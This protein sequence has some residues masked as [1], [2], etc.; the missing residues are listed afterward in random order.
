MKYEVRVLYEGVATYVVEASDVDSA[1]EAGRARYVNG[2][3]EDSTGNEW[4][5][6]ESVVSVWGTANWL[7]REVYDMFGVRFAG[8]P[9]LR[10]ILL[11]EHRPLRED[12]VNLR[13]VELAA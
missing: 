1:E 8:H 12:F 10:R 3:P 5:E 11:P 4:E 2:E 9:D 6:I 7:E 13:I